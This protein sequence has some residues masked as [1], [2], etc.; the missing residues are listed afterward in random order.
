MP[1][2][3][4]MKELAKELGRSRYTVHRWFHAGVF[5]GIRIGKRVLFDAA[6]VEAAL[7]RREVQH[8][9]KSVDG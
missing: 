7:K 6:S 4:T 3:L 9:D 8:G 5:P 2:L 1:R